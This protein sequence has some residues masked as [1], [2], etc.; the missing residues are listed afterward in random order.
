MDGQCAADGA[1]GGVQGFGFASGPR[2]LDGG[3]KDVRVPFL[4]AVVLDAIYQL[5][6]HR[7]IYPIEL[8]FTATLLALLPY[9]FLRSAVCPV[10]RRFMHPPARP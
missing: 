1:G 2:L 3:W 5:I 10:A 4:L 8:L 9:I 6:I 7:W